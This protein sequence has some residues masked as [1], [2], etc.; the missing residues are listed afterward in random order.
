MEDIERWLDSEDDD[1][2]EEGG[3]GDDSA[4]LPDDNIA[5]YSTGEDETVDGD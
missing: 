1:E 3:S 5:Q 2:G 4:S